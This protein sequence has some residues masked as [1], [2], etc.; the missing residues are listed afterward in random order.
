[1]SQDPPTVHTFH[2]PPNRV[3]KIYNRVTDATREGHIYVSIN[4]I[5]W[6]TFSN[7][8]FQERHHQNTTLNVQIFRVKTTLRPSITQRG[9]L[10]I[11]ACEDH[12]DGD[13]NDDFLF[14]QLF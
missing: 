6:G 13:H 7:R 9:Q 11:I 5:H 4:N 3:V 14:I 2:L 10:T 12:V 8:T 1:M